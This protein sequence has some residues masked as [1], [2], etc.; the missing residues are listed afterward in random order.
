MKIQETGSLAGER[1]TVGCTLPP[2]EVSAPASR[3]LRQTERR[4]DWQVSSGFGETC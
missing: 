4:A 1:E 2:E 3:N